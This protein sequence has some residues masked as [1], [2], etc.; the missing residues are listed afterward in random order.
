M[1]VAIKVRYFY[2]APASRKGRPKQAG[3]ENVVVKI[4]YRR[5]SRASIVKQVIRMAV[6]IKVSHARHAPGHRPK[7]HHRYRK[8]LAHVGT[9]E[10]SC[11]GHDVGCAWLQWGN[12]KVF[13]ANGCGCD[14]RVVAGGSE[15]QR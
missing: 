7:S 5:L 10:I 11:F 4:P 3:A 12:E 6:P 15:G 13:A 8:G 9:I 1:A 2:H 14:G